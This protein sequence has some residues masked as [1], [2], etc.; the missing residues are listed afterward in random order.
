MYTIDDHDELIEL[1]GAPKMETGA[2]H[3]IVF[4]TERSLAISY[5]VRESEE[6][7]IIRFHRP[8][9][10]LFGPPNDE[11][12]RGHPLAPRGLTSYRMFQ[13][14]NSSLVRH[15]ERMNSVHPRHDP[16]RFQDRKHYILTFHDSTFECL[17]RGFEAVVERIQAPG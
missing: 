1:T 17:A 9:F 8:S 3:P 10:H 12:I 7:A 5:W 4:S 13:V 14:L 11:A 2:P 15:L 16:K 6:L